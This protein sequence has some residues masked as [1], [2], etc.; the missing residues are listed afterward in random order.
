MKNNMQENTQYEIGEDEK[1]IDRAEENNLSE[2][3]PK[4]E[5]QRK[6]KKGKLFLA[7]V[8]LG[9]SISMVINIAVVPFVIRRQTVAKLV[10]APVSHTSQEDT[11]V[12]KKTQEKMQLLEDSIK[13]YYLEDVDSAELEKGIYRGIVAAL[14]DPYS[15]YYTMEELED[16]RESTEGIYYGI[17]AYVGIDSATGYCKITGIIPNTPAEEAGLRAEDIIYEVDGV[18]TF[19]MTTQDVVALIKGEE[20]T[21][22]LLTIA[23]KGEKDYLSVSVTRRKV[24]APT[25]NYSMKED[26][27]AYI[28]ITQFDTVTSGQFEEALI[29]AREDGM[30][31]MILD[32]RNNPGGTLDSVVKIA[33]MILPKGLIV[34]TEDKE[35]K[36]KEYSCEGENPLDVPLVVLVNENSASAAEILAGAIKDYEMGTLVGTKT[37]G[38][39]IVQKL[40]SITDGSAVKLT[41]SHYYTPKGNDIHKVGIE[42]DEELKMDYETYFEDGSDNQLDRAIE[43]LKKK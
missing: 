19:E 39:G 33:K 36:R 24:E 10:S 13:Q 22:V 15:T 11:V 43:I 5:K 16:V 6:D 38:K 18:S 9:V 34:Y 28:Q 27:I 30:K 29:K 1:A 31:K 20:N 23:R 35:G 2:K 14:G 41:V 32:L 3:E 17:G 12:T 26:A 42:P 40:F 21:T 4:D 8:L 7:G 25:V 37:F